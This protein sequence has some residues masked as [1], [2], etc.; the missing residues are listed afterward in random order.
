LFV[1]AF[2]VASSG[3]AHA[4]EEA[5]QTGTLETTVSDGDDTPP[6]DGDDEPAD[7]WWRS[8]PATPVVADVYNVIEQVV[9]IVKS[10]TTLRRHE[11]TVEY[12]SEDNTLHRYSD[13]RT[14]YEF[15]VSRV[16]REGYTPTDGELAVGDTDWWEATDPDPGILLART[17]VVRT[18][19]DAPVPEISPAPEAGAPINLGLWIA[20]EEAGPYE[21]L[22][23]LG[24][25]VWARRTATLE[26]IWFDPGNNAG[27]IWCPGRGT[28]L[29][30]S[31]SGTVDAGPCGYVYEAHADVV[32]D[33]TVTL[34]AEW[35]VTWELS[36]GTS[37]TDP[38]PLLTSTSFPYD[39]YEI[40][41]VG[42]G[43]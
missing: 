27:R 41:T 2:A 22:A 40:Q 9:V 29:P 19:V 25:R 1:L 34:E 33:L 20:I 15:K 21:A 31:Q 30:S 5:E 35:L 11:V 23:S 36:N 6:G 12:Y 32:A 38:D 7:C 37:G 13:E 16:C 28:P 26:G 24:P 3:T 4:G 43:D 18:I 42:T 14:R 17:E 10:V 39:V 8:V